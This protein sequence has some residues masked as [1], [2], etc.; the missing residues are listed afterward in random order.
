MGALPALQERLANFKAALV[1]GVED[2]WIFMVPSSLGEVTAVCA[3][4]AAFKA[5]YGGRICL[6]ADKSRESIF[7][8]FG[9]VDLMKFADMHSMRLLSSAGAID[10]LRFEV[11]HP[12]NLWVNQNRCG[13][14]FSLHQ[15]FINEPGRGG[16]S[17]MDMMRYT[18]NLPWDAAITKGT[19]GEL[20]KA[21]AAELAAAHGV[22]PGNSVILFPG[23]NT[24]KPA[25]AAFWNTIARDCEAAGKKVFHCLTGANFK[26]EGLELRG[27]A[28]DM[29]PGLAVA[30]SEIAGHVVSGSNGL[31][32]LS[33]MTE[34]TFGIDVVLTDGTDIIG[35][36]VFAP[37][38]PTW[39]STFRFCPELV[40]D[41]T[42][43]YAEWPLDANA[44]A[45]AVGSD[46]ARA[47][48]A[49]PR[50]A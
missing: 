7:H 25:S 21:S 1:N 47:I 29:P 10:P 9:D 48:E 33:L 22:E 30:V 49:S 23:N 2:C 31:V 3:L 19:L 14:G 13:R 26:P 24:N 27:T 46:V 32:T 37:V 12:Q 18:M 28:L 44:D 40:T 8:L 6:V 15:L 16:L 17:F 42:R 38:A 36:F 11:G 50:A 20:L 5:R 4:S 39:S 35:D 45:A 41:L 34:T 43:R